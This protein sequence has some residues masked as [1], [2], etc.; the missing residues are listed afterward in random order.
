MVHS[1]FTLASLLLVVGALLAFVLTAPAGAASTRHCSGSYGGGFFHGITARGVSCATARGVT[2][3]WV[4][5]SGFET[6]SFPRHGGNFRVRRFS[7]RLHEPSGGSE[8]G[9]I[10]CTASDG[11]RVRFIGHP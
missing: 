11:D 4:K 9:A 8:T 10:T 7:C 5:R 6:A 1:R 2:R 3:T